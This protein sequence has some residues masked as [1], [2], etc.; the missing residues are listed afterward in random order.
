MANSYC[1]QSDEKSSAV[2]GCECDHDY[3][4]IEGQCFKRTPEAVKAAR[5]FKSVAPAANVTKPKAGEYVLNYCVKESRRDKCHKHA[6]QTPVVFTQQGFTC[7]CKPGF[8]GDGFVCER[9]CTKGE[10][11]ENPDRETIARWRAEHGAAVRHCK[12]TVKH[13]KDKNVLSCYRPERNDGKYDQ[14][15]C[16]CLIGQF[17]KK[18]NK[19]DDFTCENV[20]ECE[21]CHTSCS[22]DSYCVDRVMGYCDSLE[23]AEKKTSCMGYSCTCRHGTSNPMGGAHTKGCEDINQCEGVE[24]KPAC[25]EHQTCVDSRFNVR[26]PFYP[27]YMCQCEHGWRGSWK[28]DELPEYTNDTA[29]TPSC[30]PHVKLPNVNAVTHILPKGFST[31]KEFTVG[32][33]AKVICADKFISLQPQAAC[34]KDGTMGAKWERQLSCTAA[35]PPIK[36][37]NGKT[38]CEEHWSVEKTVCKA[39][40]NKGYIVEYE[41]CT[42]DGAKHEWSCKDVKLPAIA[43]RP[44]IKQL[45]Q[46]HDLVVPNAHHVLGN[47]F[48][49]INQTAVLTCDKNYYEPKESIAICL[50]GNWTIR[51]KSGVHVEPEDVCVPVCKPLSIAHGTIEY[52][53]AASEHAKDTYAK[54]KCDAGYQLSGGDNAF[55]CV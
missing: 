54:I 2:Y 55:N 34:V 49:E 1:V 45:C 4:M 31:T 13:V 51:Q 9:M 48:S 37:E 40:P 52:S 11:V 30:T 38:E 20:N 18:G 27:Y 32:T 50:S 21:L 39:T 41:T 47:G 46:N 28:L 7:M 6:I 19:A 36:V 29:C 44:I 23:N 43:P 12:E 25:M 3:V 5:R 22:A 14:N 15:T 53:P 8:H 16:T 17:T 26:L 35:C 42:C 33:V 24:G 10:L